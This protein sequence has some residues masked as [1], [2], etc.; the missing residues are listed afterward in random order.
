M[1]GLRYFVCLIMKKLR[2]RYN[3]VEDPRIPSSSLAAAD[4]VPDTDF[5][6]S[7]E[8]RSAVGDGRSAPLFIALS[9]PI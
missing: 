5:R 2:N 3:D 8:A 6:D 1:N 9:E 7:V 4:L